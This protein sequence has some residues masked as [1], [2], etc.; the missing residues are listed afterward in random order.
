[1]VLKISGTESFHLKQSHKIRPVAILE[2]LTVFV[3]QSAISKRLTV[4]MGHAEL[5]LSAASPYAVSG[6]HWL[7]RDTPQSVSRALTGYNLPPETRLRSSGVIDIERAFSSF[8]AQ[9]LT[10]CGRRRK[11]TKRAIQ[12]R[13]A[14]LCMP[15]LAILPLDTLD[16]LKGNF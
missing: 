13:T 4:C 7:W 3:F 1:M 14:L 11:T 8:F 6:G 15:R 10:A 2:P 9:T 5:F 12:N 16:A